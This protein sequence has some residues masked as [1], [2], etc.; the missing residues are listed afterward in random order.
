MTTIEI[1]E[2]CVVALVGASGSGKSTFA[3]DHFLPTEVLSSDFFRGLVADDENDLA[4]TGDAFDALYTVAGKRLRRGLLTVV[5]ATNVQKPDRRHIVQ[6]ARDSDCLA[7]AIVLDL[8]EQLCVERNKSRPDRQIPRRA[9]AR[10]VS[11]LRQSLRHLRKEGFRYVFTLSSP[12]EV[13]AVNLVRQRMWVDRRDDAGPF[14]IIGD[15]HGCFNEL[16]ALLELLGYSVD[17]STLAVTA[18]DGRKAVFLGDLVDRGPETPN[19]VRLVKGMVEAGTALC[20]AGNHENKLVRKLSGRDVQMTHGLPETMAQLALEPDGFADEVLGFLDGLLSHYVFDD[21]K[22]VVSHAGLPEAYHGRA[23]G[24]VRN[25]ALFGETT[26][27]TDEFGLPVRYDW[28]SDY[29]G[30]AM[31]VYGHTTVPEAE[32][33][34]RTICLDTGCVFGGRLTALRYPEQEIVSVEAAHV[35]YEPIRPL[36]NVRD[37]SDVLDIADVTGKRFVDTSLGGRVTIPEEN[38][39]A[40]LE[41]MS[42]FAAD[43]HWII[44]LPPTM[45]PA[46]TS[47]LN[48]LLEHP[49]EAFD[50]YATRGVEKVVCEAKHMGS[51]AIIVVTRDEA[52]ATDR[53]RA[54]DGATGAVLTRT[55]RPFFETPD[56]TEEV[57]GEIRTAV[58][59]A[60]LWDELGTNWLCLDA[61]LMPWNAKAGELVTRHYAPVGAAARAMLA[62]ANAV[63]AEAATHL[64]VRDLIERYRRRATAADGFVGAY[65]NY[66]WDVSSR[67]DLRLAPFQLLAGEGR[68]YFDRDHG[69]HMAT[70]ARLAHDHGLLVATPYLEIDP[71]DESTRAEAI[72]WWTSL[73]ADGGE[74]MVVKP[75]N[76]ITK[77]RKGRLVQPGIKCRGS[78]Y[79]RIIYGID[80]DTPETLSSLRGRDLRRKRAMARREF[81]LGVEALERFVGG[82]PL[83]RVHEAVF[84]VLAIESEPVDPRL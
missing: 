27:E 31:V 10:Q 16:V 68:T 7:V 56:T 46:E 34:N 24:R 57:L 82:D 23:S 80:Y 3:A 44:Y 8:S 30:D 64:D 22:L 51:R 48:G 37:R 29:R 42:R 75:S 79:L 71:R 39:A 69:W 5:D 70:L 58:D 36:G 1:P 47:S 40:A 6:L 43:P 21:G 84:G 60:G 26:G 73:T 2:L 66:C 55:G 67:S 61:E 41:V 77:D 28:A 38:A 9:I 50:Y 4:A 78:E 54:G 25:F 13:A 17:R 18:P 20:V 62:E 45:S 32:W 14:D 74:G 53:F 59:R 72:E 65:S 83:Y 33:V 19:V 63:L 52:T 76:P 35:Y 11:N 12:E 81:V 15:V 49:A